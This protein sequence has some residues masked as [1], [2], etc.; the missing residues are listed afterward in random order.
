MT[1]K[2]NNNA[3]NSF[4]DLKLYQ[5]LFFMAGFVATVFSDKISCS[6]ETNSLGEAGHPKLPNID[7]GNLCYAK[8]GEVLVSKEPCVIEKFTLESGNCYAY[9]TSQSYERVGDLAVWPGGK[10]FRPTGSSHE[11]SCKKL[12]HKILKDNRIKSKVDTQECGSGTRELISYVSGH[13]ELY[14]IDG[15]PVSGYGMDYHVAAKGENG[16]FYHK[17]G[18]GN[19]QK[20]PK[21]HL[22]HIPEGTNSNGRATRSYDACQRYCFEL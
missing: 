2:R 11:E 10:P 6:S 15:K 20:L 17:P 5:K 13:E 12:D 4:W 22:T 19:P 9:V 14:S 18:S 21:K 3:A 16:K 1:R 8:L 7:N